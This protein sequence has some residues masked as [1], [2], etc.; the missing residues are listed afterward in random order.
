MTPQPVLPTTA[1]PDLNT[2]NQEALIKPGTSQAQTVVA[3]Q[4]TNTDSN[5]RINSAKQT[6]EQNKSSAMSVA[7]AGN[8]SKTRF[9]ASESVETS[10]TAGFSFRSRQ[11][12]CHLREDR[13]AAIKKES[14]KL[15]KAKKKQEAKELKQLQ[16]RRIQIKAAHE[17][18]KE[19][20]ELIAA[21]KWAK[22]NM[23]RDA[24][25]QEEI[26][27]I[28]AKDSEAKKLER[29]EQSIL[30]RLRE[31]H[32]R[33][34]EAI[35]EV[36][37]IFNQSGE[38]GLANDSSKMLAESQQPSASENSPRS[39]LRAFNLVVN[40]QQANERSSKLRN[41]KD[42]HSQEE[43]KSDAT[44]QKNLVLTKSI[45]EEEPVE[46]EMRNLLA[47]KDSLYEQEGEQSFIQRS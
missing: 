10:K 9:G 23:K 7:E 40:Q 38:V 12:L 45:Y 2:A 17:K 47:S 28:G 34:K 26:I 13:A 4:L 37:N 21:Q 39:Y 46:Q 3:D 43:A 29:K 8:T 14:I 20:T 16:E 33:Q 22:A 18:V 25:I 15:V 30:K 36:Y 24:I 42:N 32:T 31:T 1:Q 11:E 27:K 41:S 6:E 19:K 35:E 44:T 5:P